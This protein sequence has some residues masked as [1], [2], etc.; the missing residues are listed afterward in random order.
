MERTSTAEW[1]HGRQAPLRLYNSLTRQLGVFEAVKDNHVRVYTCGPTVYNYAHIGNLR[2]YIFADTLRRTLQWKGYDVTHVINITDVGHLTSD[3]DTGE[4]KVE[5]AARAAH[6]SAY[7]ITENYTSA[8]FSDLGDLNVCPAAIYP[9]ATRHI[10]EMIAFIR[11]LEQRGLT[12]RL[13]DGLYFDT[14]K[15]SDYGRLG[16]LDLD[17]QFQGQ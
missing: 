8:F 15:V 7:E 16:A 10:Q 4:D 5:L 3:A 12:Y 14:S 2:A 9:R 13:E 6:R 1:D 17:D 11:V